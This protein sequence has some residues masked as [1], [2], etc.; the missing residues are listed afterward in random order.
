MSSLTELFD[1]GWIFL[2]AVLLWLGHRGWR[3]LRQRPHPF[4]P[5]G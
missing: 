1:A 2:I 5:N 3:G 4:L